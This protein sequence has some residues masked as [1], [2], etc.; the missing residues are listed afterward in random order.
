MIKRSMVAQCQPA[1]ISIFR[2]GIRPERISSATTFAARRAL[3]LANA[4]SRTTN[5]VN[6][7]GS[8]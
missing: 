7:S 5:N 1:V 6:P 4:S 2:G 3:M 8:A